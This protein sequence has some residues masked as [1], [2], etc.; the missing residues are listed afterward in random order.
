MKNFK[1][2]N[3]NYSYYIDEKNKKVIAVSTYAGKVVKGIAKADPVD[4][5]NLEFGKKLAAARCNE[6]ISKKRMIKAISKEGE[7][8]KQLMKAVFNYNEAYKYKE[9][10]IKRH[11]DAERE[12]VELLQI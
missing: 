5:F 1:N 4:N 3:Y 12:V 11:I 2:K 6:K 7:A 8:L 10:A 9:D